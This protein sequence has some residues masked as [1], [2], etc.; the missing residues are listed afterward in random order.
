MN[1]SADEVIDTKTAVQEVDTNC[2][3]DNEGC[4]LWAVD[5]VCDCPEEHGETQRNKHKTG[6]LGIVQQF[7][8][9][10]VGALEIGHLVHD[11]PPDTRD[12]EF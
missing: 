6:N 11:N 4:N 7:L 9:D 10:I 5:E 2:P 12:G 8:D 3:Y 1:E